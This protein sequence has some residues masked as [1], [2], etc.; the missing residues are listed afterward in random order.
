MDLY[1]FCTAEYRQVLD[2]PRKRFQ[3]L[4]NE[5]VEKRLTTKEPAPS[6]DG[7]SEKIEEVLQIRGRLFYCA[8]PPQG[9]AAQSEVEKKDSEQNL[10][11]QAA[12]SEEQPTVK[13]KSLDPLEMIIT[14]FVC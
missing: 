6:A 8:Y 10:T 7:Q 14:L 5:E 11:V 2:G 12:D 1:E 13:V 4:R 9:S 3:D